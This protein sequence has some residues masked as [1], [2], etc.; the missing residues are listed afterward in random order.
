M[1]PEELRLHGHEVA[2]WIAGYLEDIRGYPVL[3]DMRPGDLVDSLPA[4]GPERGEPMDTILAD[5]RAHIVPALTHWN[6]PRFF[7]FFSVSASGPGI[8]GEMLAAALNVNG[9]LWKSCPAA[10]ELEQVTL[11]WLRDWIGLP[12]EF[13]GIIYDTASISTLHAV[14]AARERADP[15]ARRRGTR[16]DLVLYT[17]EQS[18]SSI[19]KAAITLGLGQDNV[20][21]IPVDNAFRMR[22][23][24]LEHA[25]AADLAAG[26]R[27][28]CVV[29][30]TGTTSTSSIDP[31]AAIGEVARRHNLWLHVDAAYGGSAAVAPDFAWVLAGAAQ[32]DSLVIN[33][34][35]WLFT[36]ID[37][38]VLYT[39]H[40]EILRRAFSLVPEYLKTADDPRAI[41]FMDYG[42]QLGRRFRSLKLWF[43]LRYFGREGIAALIR[44]HVGY[45]Q[46]LAALIAADVR[47]EVCAPVPLSLVCFRLR[48]SDEKNREMLDRVNR[49]G[50]AF[51][52]H[53]VLNGK[54]VLRL[55]IGNIATTWEDVAAAWAVVS[56]G[57]YEGRPAKR[58]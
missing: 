9:M 4:S 8:L 27:P 53:T 25:I 55:A 40:P 50:V 46:R 31:V 51:L 45:A 7:A 41:N 2:D 19:E 47:F 6:H 37:L 17:S 42:V 1:T 14:A 58:F 56:D 11:G 13:F 22:V 44:S 48:D 28:F 36:P 34:H 20:R 57:V 29:A 26:K 3:P 30:T 12:P 18:H 49:S 32:A 5:F 24:A 54:F 43:V 35:K 10:S 16:G 52:S 39:R 15:D 21:H 23:E 33:P 38:S